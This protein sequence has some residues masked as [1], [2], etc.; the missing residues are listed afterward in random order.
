MLLRQPIST[1]TDPLLPY[2]ALFRS[3]ELD[4][5]Y[6]LARAYCELDG[7]DWFDLSRYTPEQLQPLAADPERIETRMAQWSPPTRFGER[8]RETIAKAAN[9]DLLLY[10][11]VTA[12]EAAED[13]G[14]VTGVSIAAIGG[15][16]GIPVPL[17]AKI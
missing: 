6:R 15:A 9:I 4:P 12:I 14:H 17:I 3:A 7:E 10:A 1:L 11:N 5:H 8:H 16:R 13:A 2:P